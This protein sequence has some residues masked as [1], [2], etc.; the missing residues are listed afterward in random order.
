MQSKLSLGDR[1]KGA[2]NDK[3]LSKSALGKIVGTSGTSINNIENGETKNPGSILLTKIAQELQVDLDWLLY[4]DESLPSNSITGNN[5]SGNQWQGENMSYTKGSAHYERE[6]RIA[7]LE[8][9]GLKR[10]VERLEKYIKLL[11]KQAGV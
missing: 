5:N 11:E 8:I 1:L 7:N 3:G 4:G 10:E 9:E 6:L 2:R